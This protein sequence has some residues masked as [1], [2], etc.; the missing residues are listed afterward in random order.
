MREG[1]ITCDFCGVST[2]KNDEMAKY[3]TISLAPTGKDIVTGDTEK[4]ICPSCKTKFGIKVSR[5]RQTY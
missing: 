5:A 3:D 2:E 1:K 4:D